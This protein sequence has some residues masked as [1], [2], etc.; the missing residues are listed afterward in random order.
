MAVSSVVHTRGN[1]LPSSVLLVLQRG[2]HEMVSGHVRSARWSQPVR[3]DGTARLIAIKRSQ[4][5]GRV[6]WT[7]T[8]LAGW[9]VTVEKSI[10]SCPTLHVS[11]TGWTQIGFEKPEFPGSEGLDLVPCRSDRSGRSLSCVTRGWPTSTGWWG[12]G[13]ITQVVARAHWQRLLERTLCLRM[14]ATGQWQVFV[15]FGC[16]RVKSLLFSRLEAASLLPSAQ[17]CG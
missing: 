2:S 11:M 12:P 16:S 15:L 5:L 10:R 17:V 3:R 14:V 4:T 6:K 13:P 9:R 1:F 7:R 8:R